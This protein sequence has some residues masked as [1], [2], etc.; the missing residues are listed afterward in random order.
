MLDSIFDTTWLLA[1]PAAFLALWL[2]H[3]PLES[4][5]IPTTKALKVLLWIA[6]ISIT[7]YSAAHLLGMISGNLSW[8]STVPLLAS[9]IANTFYAIASNRRGPPAVPS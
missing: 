6:I 4:M 2:N 8:L 1:I 9:F 7:G 5:F 3:L